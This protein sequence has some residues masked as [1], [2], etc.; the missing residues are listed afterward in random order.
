M[1]EVEVGLKLVFIKKSHNIPFEYQA[2][3][4]FKSP[5]CFN[6]DKCCH[7]TFVSNIEKRDKIFIFKGHASV[8]LK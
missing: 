7:K 3:L 4:E 5:L 6:R 8:T 1:N 2:S